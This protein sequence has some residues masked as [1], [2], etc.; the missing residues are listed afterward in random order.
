MNKRITIDV[1][2]FFTI[3][4]IRV[5]RRKCIRGSRDIYIIGSEKKREGGQI[6]RMSVSGGQKAIIHFSQ[7]SP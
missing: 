5:D 6:T 2:L 1:E 3:N 7:R 4:K